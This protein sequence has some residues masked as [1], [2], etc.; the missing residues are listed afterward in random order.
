MEFTKKDLPGS[1]QEIE[2][3][4]SPEEVEGHREKALT[5]FGKE[6]SL[7]GFRPGH[8]PKEMVAQKVSRQQVFAKAMEL[9]IQDAYQKI[10]KEEDLKV[11]G[12]PE[13]RIV[14]AKDGEPVV[15]SIQVS[16]FPE[17][18]LPDYKK[19]ASEV[20]KKEV[21]V[22]DEDLTRTLKWLQESKKNED[23]TLPELN[24]EFA[25]TLGNASGLD[26]LKE[27]VKKGLMMEKETQEKNRARQE[28]VAKV[29]KEATFEV[30][31]VLVKR[32][33]QALLE[34]TKQGVK[35][36]LKIEF[37]EYLK[38][39]K[40]TEE[41]LKESFLVQAQQRIGEFLVLDAIAKKEEITASKEEIEEEM[42]KV[43]GQYP[44]S[45]LAKDSLDQKE[46]KMYSEGVLRNEKTLQ[47]LEGLMK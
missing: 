23:G 29:A 30:P 31:E 2:V 16:L 40:K 43:L 42:Q 27:S 1:R 6:V 8:A 41:E 24:D 46:L 18:T 37:T 17:V 4:I 5:L 9:A 14:K 19:I 38:N 7:E 13:V 12:D 36:M 26:E 3:I 28:I 15:F 34:Q 35:E 44:E 10:A 39:M 20:T 11:L 45:K 32:E 21:I 47:L 33:Q 22:Q 25:K